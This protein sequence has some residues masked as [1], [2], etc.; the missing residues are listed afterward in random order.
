LITPPSNLRRG[1]GDDRLVMTGWPMIPGLMRSVPVVV[2][3]S[4]RFVVA[5]SNRFGVR[6]ATAD[7]AVVNVADALAGK[8]ALTGH[9]RAGMFPRQF[10]LEPGGRV[11]L[12]T[13]HVS[14]QVPAVPLAAVP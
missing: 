8:P 7:L 14:R 1:T 9:I 5:H 10:A 13:N 11:L 6:G 2:A 4:N 12:V 3:H